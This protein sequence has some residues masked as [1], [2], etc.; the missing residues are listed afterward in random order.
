MTNY[1]P[2]T[3]SALGLYVCSAAGEGPAADTWCR[4]SGLRLQ[5]SHTMSG[6]FMWVWGLRFCVWTKDGNYTVYRNHVWHVWHVIWS[7]TEQT[8]IFTSHTHQE[9][10]P[11]E[12]NGGVVASQVPVALFSVKLDRKAS[13]ISHGVCWPRF[14]SWKETH[15]SHESA[16]SAAMILPLCTR[17]V[18]LTHG[19]EADSDGC[20]LPDMFKHLGFAIASDVM[21][22][23]K[24]AK[25]SCIM[26]ETIS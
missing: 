21:S 2:T 10:I 20:R 18:L 22:H 7:I 1:Q 17:L 26:Q 3:L 12:E 23:L 16:V 25:R 19:G 6:S 14:T 4:L 15:L 9:G 24:V 8:K 11:D 5:K 13:W